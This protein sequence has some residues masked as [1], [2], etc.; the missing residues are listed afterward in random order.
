[1]RNRRKV[2]KKDLAIRKDDEARGGMC[3]STAGIKT[4]SRDDDYESIDH[5]DILRE[6]QDEKWQCN[7][8]IAIV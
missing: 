7:V 8:A 2:K 4:H 3:D 5:D 1:M 6:K